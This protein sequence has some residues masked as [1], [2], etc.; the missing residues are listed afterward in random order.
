MFKVPCGFYDVHLG[1]LFGHRVLLLT[2]RGR[3]SGLVHETALEVIR[4]VRATDSSVVISAYG[5]K[6]DWFRRNGAPGC[7]PPASTGRVSARDFARLDDSPLIADLHIAES[8][9]A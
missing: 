1:W 8:P 7:L 2:Y 3:K 4:S 9:E 5:P 6:S